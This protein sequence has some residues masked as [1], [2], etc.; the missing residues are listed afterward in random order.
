[1]N[2]FVA[3]ASGAIGRRLVPLLV[4]AGH[5]V[6]AMT[7]APQKGRVLEEL[8]ARPVVADGLDRAA[9]MQAVLR[10]EP[11]VLI[12]EMTGLAGVTSF[13]N[14]DDELARCVAVGNGHCGLAAHDIDR[15][16]RHRASRDAVT[17]TDPARAAMGASSS[18]RRAASSLR[19]MVTLRP[20]HSPERRPSTVSARTVWSARI[21]RYS[22]DSPANWSMAWCRSGERECSMGS[23]STA[24]R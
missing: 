13:K 8:G 22:P 17:F 19:G 10:A 11:E 12:H 23:P 3:G 9:V 4:A 16:G 24:N 2:V 20:S 21:R 7:H 18:A 5:D 15:S 6:F 1:M 14:L